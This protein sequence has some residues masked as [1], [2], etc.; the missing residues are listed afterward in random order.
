M[1]NSSR[2]FVLASRGSQLAQIQTNLAMD[3]MKSLFAGSTADEIPKFTTS[4]MSTAGDKNQSQALYLLGGKA[5]WTKEL[6]VALIER[7]VDMLVHSLKDVPTVLPDGCIIAGIMEREDPVDSLVVKKNSPWKTLDDLPNGSI[8]GTSSVRR[9]AQLKRKYP[10]LVFQDVR[11]NLNTRMAKLDAP[12][13]PYAAI[14]LAKAGMVR[15]GMSDRLTSD[16]APPLLYH[17]VSQGALAIEIRSNDEE[18]LKICQQITHWETA[19][20]CLAERACLRKLEGGCSV[21]VGIGS[22]LDG[23]V[24]TI[25]GCV[26]ALDGSKHVDHTIIEMVTNEEQAEAVGTKLAITLIETGA[27]EILDD[28]TIDREM[29]IKLAQEKDE[30]IAT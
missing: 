14:V 23:D 12:D 10:D 26:T 11:G 18:S 5:L 27:K 21:P 22:S 17:A 13:G 9:V 7:E 20:C 24:L 2:T 8:V 19:W 25:T 30:N 6:E 16:L 1:S 15:L 29:K 3:S 4:F 28:I